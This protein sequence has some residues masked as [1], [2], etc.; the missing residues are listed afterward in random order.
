MFNK[1][2]LMATVFLI[3]ILLFVAYVKRKVIVSAFL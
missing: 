1:K 3:F 2:L